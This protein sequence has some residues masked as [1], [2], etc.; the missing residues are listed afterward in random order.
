LRS[1][2]GFALTYTG[3][4]IIHYV[5]KIVYIELSR[6]LIFFLTL[7]LCGLNAWFYLRKRKRFQLCRH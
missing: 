5:E 7:L 2:H 1:K 6:I 4:F 3:S